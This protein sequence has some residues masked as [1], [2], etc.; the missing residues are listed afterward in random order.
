VSL[1]DAAEI[2]LLK[3]LTGQATAIF[4]TTPYTPHLALFTVA[5]T[6]AAGGTEAAGGG[7]ARLPVTGL[8]ATPTP[9]EAHNSA[10]VALA[11]FT[12]IVS[13][14]AAFVAFGLFTA[15]TGGTLVISGP[16]TDPTKTGAGG[17]QIVFAPGDLILT[18]D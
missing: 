9:G 3:L 7:Y 11:A 15:L 2:D 17:D 5:P 16:L 14:G 1:T 8:F 18:A 12:G 10:Q 13:G 6:D 4:T